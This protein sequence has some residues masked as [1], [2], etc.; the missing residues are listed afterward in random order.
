MQREKKKGIRNLFTVR[1]LQLFSK[2]LL[3]IFRDC[4]VKNLRIKLLKVDLY[5][6]YS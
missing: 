3:L 1:I 4:T 6:V 2:W 5:Q